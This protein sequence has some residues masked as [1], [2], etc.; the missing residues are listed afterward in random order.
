MLNYLLLLNLVL[1]VF[2]VGIFIWVC[3]VVGVLFVFFFKN[4]N[5]KWGNVMLGFVVGVMFVVSFWLFFVFVIEMSKDLGKFFFVLVLVGF[6]F[7]GIFLCVIDCIIL[8]LYFGF[9][10]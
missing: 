4:L 2:F 1:L 10:E 7:G 9:L 5:K 6:L 8:Y 3:I